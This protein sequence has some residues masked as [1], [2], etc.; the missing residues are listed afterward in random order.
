MTASRTILRRFMSDQAG[1]SAVEYGL[2]VGLIALGVALAIGDVG[3]E[4]LFR[5]MVKLFSVATA[6]VAIP[7]IA[8]LLSRRVTHAGA[9]GGFLGGI[10]VGIIVFFVCP[11]AVAWRGMMLKKETVILFSTIPST[12]AATWLAVRMGRPGASEQ[13]RAES[14]LR[15]LDVPIGR[16]EQDGAA[17]DGQGGIPPFGVVGVSLLLIGA[18]MLAILPDVQ[19]GPAHTINAWIGAAL[20]AVGGVMVLGGWWAGK[21]KE[22]ST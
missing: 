6:P 17:A 3:G 20:V 4:G 10:V 21:A 15:R 1:A 16:L 13:A 11:D 22:R 8:G 7:M 18:L 5:S 12:L 2:L 19:E 14:F 9:L